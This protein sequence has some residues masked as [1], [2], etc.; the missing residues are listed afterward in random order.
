MAFA[1]VGFVTLF[2]IGF[3]YLKTSDPVNIED[4]KAMYNLAQLFFNNI[5]SCVSVNGSPG[6]WPAS[7]EHPCLV[8]TIG[9][10]SELSLKKAGYNCPPGA[11]CEAS[12]MVNEKKEV[13]NQYLSITRTVDEKEYKVRTEFFFDK[14]KNSGIDCRYSA[15]TTQPH[16][17]LK[18][19]ET[20]TINLKKLFTF[21]EGNIRGKVVSFD[22]KKVILEIKGE[23]KIKVSRSAISE[24]YKLKPD[25]KLKIGERIQ[26]RISF[27]DIRRQLSKQ[28][29]QKTREVS[30][31]PTRL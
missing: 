26:A 3:Y 13:T 27:K 10:E 23:R 24:C 20:K 8:S 17:T 4:K 5:K 16:I 30:S 22:K 1:L 9:Y 14:P 31:N 2:F 12:P 18:A 19:G 6:K 21:T 25:Y 29:K 28:K 11:K 7:S 15:I